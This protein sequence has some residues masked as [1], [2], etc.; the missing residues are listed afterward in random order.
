[1]KIYSHREATPTPEELEFGH[2]G[3]AP[4]RR[5]VPVREAKWETCEIHDAEGIRARNGYVRCHWFQARAS[6]PRGP[7]LAAES[8]S[9]YCPDF[10]PDAGYAAS[11]HAALVAHL[12][13][14]GWEQTDECG[15]GWWS[16]KFRRPV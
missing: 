9:F 4:E 3:G 2:L 14:D 12:I 7:Y 16:L 1:M 10:A 15:R 11:Q 8:A 6:G 5:S 13:A